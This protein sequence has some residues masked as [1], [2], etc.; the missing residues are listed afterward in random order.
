MLLKKE[1]VSSIA[2]KISKLTKQADNISSGIIDIPNNNYYDSSGVPQPR[3][4]GEPQD[5]YVYDYYIDHDIEPPWF[6]D[7]RNR[8]EGSPVNWEYVFR[9]LEDGRTKDETA[10]LIRKF[11]RQH[12]NLHLSLQKRELSSIT[13]CT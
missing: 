4:D 13:Q 11:I 1:T 8:R 9:S 12:G 10:Y 5:D 3:L 2:T 6:D 7:Y